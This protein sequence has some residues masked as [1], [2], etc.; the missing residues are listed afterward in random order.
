MHLNSHFI[1]LERKD[2]KL[3]ME[4]IA[5]VHRGI[6]PFSPINLKIMSRTYRYALGH[7]GNRCK[8]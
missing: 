2:E 1:E 5:D 4:K 8:K 7:M 6:I 3:R